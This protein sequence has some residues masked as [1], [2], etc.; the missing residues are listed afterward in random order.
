LCPNRLGGGAWLLR[1]FGKGGEEL[2]EAGRVTVY[3]N[4]KER[5]VE[6]VTREF[7]Y[8]SRRLLTNP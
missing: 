2:G 4:A 5:E 3:E 8:H 6:D 7:E 1:Y